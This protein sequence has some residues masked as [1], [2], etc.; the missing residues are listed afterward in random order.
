MFSIEPLPSTRRVRRC[1]LSWIFNISFSPVQLEWEADEYKVY[2]LFKK[3]SSGGLDWTFFTLMTPFALGC[4]RYSVGFFFDIANHFH[5]AV[6]GE[7][8]LSKAPKAEQKL[9]HSF[10][11]KSFEDRPSENSDWTFFQ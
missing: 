4:D 10:F 7:R 3:C 5:S 1:E 8:G 2:P 9:D 6:N 11:N